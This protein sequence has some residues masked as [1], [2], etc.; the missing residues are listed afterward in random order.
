M[1]ANQT[2]FSKSD[3]TMKPNSDKESGKKIHRGAWL[4]I[5]LF[6]LWSV[7][8]ALGTFVFGDSQDIRKPI[9]VLIVTSIFLAIWIGFAL[10]R[11]Q[12]TK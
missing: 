8:I 6:G 5:V 1:S 11:S 7:L 4:V 10:R 3:P 12:L 2:I 9:I